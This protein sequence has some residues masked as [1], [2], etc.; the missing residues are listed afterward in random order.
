M[1]K[2]KEHELRAFCFGV[3]RV[4]VAL[5]LCNQALNDPR[6]KHI[7]VFSRWVSMKELYVNH[8]NDVP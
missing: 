5:L 8:H 7:E 4:F 3:C 1:F 6:S 2:N